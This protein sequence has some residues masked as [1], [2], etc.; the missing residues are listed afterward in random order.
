MKHTSS[1]SIQKKQNL[2][3]QFLRMSQKGTVT[4][5]EEA[6]FLDMMELCL[7]RGQHQ[8]V[9]VIAEEAIAQ[10]PFSV[11]TLLG[12]AESHLKLK[13]VGETLVTIQKAKALSP[14]DI[15]A[16]LL[17]IRVMMAQRQFTA[18]LVYLETIQKNVD[19]KEDEALCWLIEAQLHRALKNPTAEFRCLAA[20]LLADPNNTEGYDRL[21]WVTDQYGY[22][23][24]S[25]AL[26]NR[27][28]DRDAY[29]EWAWYNLGMIHEALSDYAEA[30]EAFEYVIAIDDKCHAAYMSLGE[31]YIQT[32]QYLTAQMI[33][34]A[35]IFKIERDGVLLHK[36][37]VCY[38]K[39]GQ[40]EAALALFEQ[41]SRFQNDADTD[42]DNIYRVGQC[43]AALGKWQK[44]IDCYQK[45]IAGNSQREDYHAALGEAYHQTEQYSKA[46]ACY[47]RAAIIA[48]DV[49][50]NWVRFAEF[51][52]E[53]G[54]NRKALR[55]LDDA[56]L[57]SFGAEIEY[58]RTACLYAMGRTTEAL[59]SL[60]DALQQDFDK[61]TSLSRWQPN[62][63]ESADFQ[64]VIQQYSER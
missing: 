57:H 17:S 53:V 33:Y 46:I 3:T 23:D 18:A 31:L 5:I 2:L 26:Y 39:Q 58:C 7:A 21:M 62:L 55:V 20:A 12:K 49:A 16:D 32:K 4:F 43:Y 60:T 35:A 48:P 29:N 8:T 47:R 36:L 6:D 44:A 13:Q 40:T 59:D 50:K 14:A 34:E 24:E 61:H 28:L 22:Y 27:L 37:G 19:T 45:A 42:T 25:I 1:S 15:R 51:W 56:L 38:L 52:L 10:H 63:L 9:L 64:A 11:D 41:S 54:Q 30:I